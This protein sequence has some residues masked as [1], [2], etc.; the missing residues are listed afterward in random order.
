MVKING[1]DYTK[2]VVLPIKTQYS[3]DKSLDQGILTLKNMTLSE[4]FE[5]LTEI[6]IDNERFIIGVDNVLQ[7]TYGSNK[8]YNHTI[9]FIEE[10]KLLEKYF[11]DT[12]TFTNSLIKKY[13]SSSVIYSNHIELGE[14]DLAKYFEEFNNQTSDTAKPLNLDDFEVYKFVDN[15][16]PNDE[17]FLTPVIGSSYITTTLFLKATGITGIEDNETYIRRVAYRMYNDANDLIVSSNMGKNISYSSANYQVGNVYR[18][19]FVCLQAPKKTDLIATK[20]FAFGIKYYIACVNDNKETLDITITD[21]VNRLLEIT[22]TRRVGSSP[23]FIFNEEQV[24]KYKNVLAPEFAITKSTLREGVQQIGSYIHA[25]PRLI[26]NVIYFDELNNREY[27]NLNN[28]YVVYNSKQDIEQFCSELDSNVDNLV[29]IDDEQSGTIIEP[30][31]DGFKTTRTEIGVVDITDSNA[32]IETTKPIEKIVKLEFGFLNNNTYVGDITPYVYEKAEYSTLD[33]YDG[34]FPYSKAWALYYTQ[35]QK[36]I[37]GLNFEEQDAISQY[38][39]K[40][41]IINILERATQ[42]TISETKN[43]ISKMQF[44]ITYIPVISARIKQHKQYIGATSKKSIL[45]YN[46]SANK[47]DTDYYGENLK[48]AVA[49]FGNIEKT[50]TYIIKNKKDIPKAGQLFNKDYVISTIITEKLNNHYKVTIGISKDFNRWNEYVGVNTNQRFYEVSEKQSVERYVIYEDYCILSNNFPIEENEFDR[51]LISENGLKI[52]KQNITPPTDIND[53]VNETEITCMAFTGFKGDTVIS[54]VIMPAVAFALGNSAFYQINMDNNF[55]AGTYVQGFTSLKGY[56]SQKKYGDTFGNIDTIKI[57]GYCKPMTTTP[58]NY[59]DAVNEGSKIPDV[60]PTNSEV[61]FTTGN[62]NIILKKD[63]RE[64]INFSYQIHCVTD[65]ENLIV[66][67]GLSKKIGTK[68]ISF[69]NKEYADCYIMNREIGKFEKEI[70][71]LPSSDMRI[72]LTTNIDIENKQID[73]ASIIC[74]SSGKSIIIVDR[75]T[76]E[77]LFAINDEIMNNQTYQLPSLM[78]RHKIYGS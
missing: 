65:N 2:Y 34:V 56:Q 63:S 72:E 12:C 23:R 47:V 45:N 27:A 74:N 6:E 66:G 57:D 13:T 46:A 78:F 61:T 11:V 29:N 16:N 54:T 10:T 77:L 75:K 49:R 3:L 14:L 5:P 69:D 8:K 24:E 62:A 1:I 41:A 48:G 43:P 50:Y 55:G 4:P 30:Y 35:G 28:K 64:N 20:G 15:F 52:L 22:E 40:Y 21:V 70:L 18:L 36:N 25:E 73:F 31:F 9:T 7:S 42:T 33:S 32:F 58:L 67:S 71:D 76:K 19:E 39:K 68:I 17:A 59:N 44:R 60:S 51:S 38:F 53:W 26:G 37:Y